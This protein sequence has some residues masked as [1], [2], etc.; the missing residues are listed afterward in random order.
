MG[1]SVPKGIKSKANVLLKEMPES[2]GTSFE[3]NKLAIKA[4]TLPFS[5]WTTNVMAGF[6]TRHHKKII[7]AEK[8][9]E[10]AKKKAQT[11]MKAPADM[12]M[13]PRPRAP[14]KEVREQPVEVTAE[15]AKE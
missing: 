6:I 7:K 12:D 5:K 8:K 10:E 15:A 11:T 1:K 13:K 9:K 2:F 14:R 4:L 3:T